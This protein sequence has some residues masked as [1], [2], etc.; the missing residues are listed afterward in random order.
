MSTVS[1]SPGGRIRRSVRFSQVESQNAQAQPLRQRFTVADHIDARTFQHT[2]DWTEG[3]E[4]SPSGRFRVIEEAKPR[5]KLFS[6]EG[7]RWDT[8]WIVIL[9]AVVLM[10]AVLL[11]DLA[12]MGIGSRTI[13]RLNSKITEQGRQN[14]TLK[15]E[16]DVS[17]G[18]VSVCTEAVKLNLISGYGATTVQLTVPQEMSAGAVTADIRGAATGWTSGSMGD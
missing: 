10:G 4:M 2:Q 18:D 12:G 11:A 7:I 5:Q 13:A 16:L 9:A 1:A 15:Q 14:A 8:A 3:M 17:A 6:R